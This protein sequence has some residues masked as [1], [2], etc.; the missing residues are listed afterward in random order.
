MKTGSF[1]SRN[2]ILDFVEESQFNQKF[3]DHLSFLDD[4]K[5]NRKDPF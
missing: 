3:L 1:G 5:Q 2:E 4:F